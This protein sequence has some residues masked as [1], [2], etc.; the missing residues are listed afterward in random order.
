[1]KCPYCGNE[2]E[3]GYILAS[4][5]AYWVKKGR[6]ALFPRRSKGDITLVGLW[7]LTSGDNSYLCRGCGRIITEVSRPLG[8]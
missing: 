4:R 1:M 5:G 7:S 3:Q 2:M 8:E 6:E